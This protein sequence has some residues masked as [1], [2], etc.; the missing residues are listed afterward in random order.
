MNRL[1]VV[2]SSISVTGASADHRLPL[3][4]S[5]VEGFARSVAAGLGL[6]VGGATTDHTELVVA[7]V[8]ELERCGGRCVVL[9]GDAQPPA[10]HALAHAMNETLGAVGR[11]VAYT[12]PV[13]AESVDR[14]ASLKALVADMHGAKVKMLVVLGGNPVFTAPAD[15][16]IAYAMEKV[17]L[18]IRPRPLRRRDVGALPLADPRGPFPRDL[19]R[20]AGLRRHRDGDAAAHRPALRRQVGPRGDRGA[21]AP[22]GRATTS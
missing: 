22:I 16:N 17:A 8:K 19:E 13:E 4:P 12:A 18:R 20:R 14:L 9:A 2:E 21:S 5:E 6:A 7:V 1:Y 15:L 3:R 10:V 11:A